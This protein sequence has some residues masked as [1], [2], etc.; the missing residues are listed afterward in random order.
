MEEKEWEKVFD[1]EFMAVGAEIEGFKRQEYR[2][3]RTHQYEQVKDFTRNLLTTQKQLLIKKVEGLR[4]MKDA[5][6]GDIPSAYKSYNQA[7]HDVLEALTN[8]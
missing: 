3:L 7:L 6:Q 2:Q 8:E 5:M 4:L 1:R